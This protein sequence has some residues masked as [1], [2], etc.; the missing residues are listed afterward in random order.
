MEKKVSK[1]HDV[2]ASPTK[3]TSLVDDLLR[4]AGR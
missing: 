3:L 4:R 2:E 1:I